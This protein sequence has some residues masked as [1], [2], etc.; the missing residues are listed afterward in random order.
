MH[1]FSFLISLS[2]LL[3]L[4]PQ[5]YSSGTMNEDEA[6][7]VDRVDVSSEADRQRLSVTAGLLA[8]YEIAGKKLIANLN[9]ETSKAE[10]VSNQAS[11][12]LHLSE[13]IIKSAQY[14]LPQCDEYLAKTVAVKAVLKDMSH[15]ALE[16]DYHHDGALP[17]A[18]GECYHTKDLFVHPAT[19]IILTRDDPSLNKATRASINAEISEVLAHTEIVRQLVVY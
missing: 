5:T 4:S 9:D 15:D 6:R 16:K 13:D 2:L 3:G 1:K 17:K 7:N 10:D 11:N 19:V 18:P 12:L 14:R 8:D